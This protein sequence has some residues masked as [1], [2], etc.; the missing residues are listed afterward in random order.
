MFEFTTYYLLLATYYLLLTTYYL[1]LTTYYL[2]LATYYVHAHANINSMRLGLEC[3]KCLVQWRKSRFVCVVVLA[4]DTVLLRLRAVFSIDA[5][6]CCFD[7]YI[8]R[9]LSSS[10][11]GSQFVLRCLSWVSVSGCLGI[12]LQMTDASSWAGKRRYLRILRRLL[13]LT[14][15]GRGVLAQQGTGTAWWTRISVQCKR[16]S[17]PRFWSATSA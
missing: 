1:L 15:W 14:Y 6:C 5:W 2:L 3:I 11:H 9:L 12:W 4:Y 7:D 16:S 10:Y 13:A 8:R 17:E